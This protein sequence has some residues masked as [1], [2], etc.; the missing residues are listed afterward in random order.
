MDKN[1]NPPAIPCPST[2]HR[3]PHEGMSLHEY[4]AG[5]TL[6]GSAANPISL[7]MEADE[8]AYASYKVAAAMLEERKKHM[9][10]ASG[11]TPS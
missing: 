5:Q 8:M 1:S 6:A 2:V 9:T 11:N 4:F 7:K 10:D 3:E